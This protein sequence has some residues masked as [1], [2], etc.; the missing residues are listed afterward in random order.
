MI[1]VQLYK[2]PIVSV[3]VHGLSGYVDDMLLS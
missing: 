3:A 1:F 2:D